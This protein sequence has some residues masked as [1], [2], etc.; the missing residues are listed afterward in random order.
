MTY[1]LMTEDKP[2]KFTELQTL[3]NFSLA[4]VTQEA[5]RLADEL[6][7]PVYIFQVVSVVT[8]GVSDNLPLA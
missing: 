8:P 7:Q 6:R 3:K 1:H 2:G 5:R 4:D